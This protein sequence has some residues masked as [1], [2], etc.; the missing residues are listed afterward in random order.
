MDRFLIE[1]LRSGRAWVLV[2]SGPSSEMGYP[3]W[4]KLGKVALET[5]KA[6]HPGRL[7]RSIEAALHSGDFPGVFEDAQGILGAP[8]LLQALRAEL[9]PSRSA[10][11]YKLICRWPV[12]VYLTTNYDDELQRQLSTLG[13]TYISYTNS[14]EHMAHLV[15]DLQGAI[16]KLHA[17]LRS[18]SGLILTRSHYKAIQSDESWQYWRTKMTSVFQMTSLVV[19]GHSLSD[20]NFQHVL[21]AA[22]QGAGVQLPVCWIAPDIT[23]DQAQ[24]YLEKFRIRVISYNNRDGDHANLFRLLEQITDFIPARTSVRISDYGKRVIEHHGSAAPAFFVFNHLAART[25]YQEKRREILIAAI[26]SAAPTLAELPSFTIK[27]ALERAGWPSGI[28]LPNDVELDVGTVA[29]DRGLL[30]KEA[31]AYKLATRGLEVSGDNRRAFQHIHDRFN[32]A[33]ARR[34]RAD[35][36]SVS[37]E[38][39][40]NL[41]RDIEAAL[42]GY[43]REGG[44]TLASLLFSAGS[45]SERVVVP[46]SVLRFMNE[47]SAQYGDLLDRQVFMRT[48]L[49]IF[50][51]AGSAERDYLG[52]LAQ[53]FFGF[54]ALGAFG[55]VAVERLQHSKGTVWLLDSN[56]QIA[57]LAIG[58]VTSDVWQ[59][60]VR[61]F[62]MSQIRFFTLDR[63]FEEI[64]EHWWFAEKMVKQHGPASRTVIAAAL[65]ESPFHRSNLFLE[66]FVRW[67]AAGN[68]ADWESYMFQVFGTRSPTVEHIRKRLLEY[69]IEVLS[70]A[71][72]PGFKE[73]DFAVRDEHANEIARLRSRQGRA[74]AGS[75]EEQLRAPYKKAL[76]EAEALVVVQRERSGNYHMLS[77]EG[78]TSPAW[79]VSDTSILNAINMNIGGLRVTWQPEAF[80][81]FAA[82]LSTAEGGRAAERAFD[83]LLWGLAQTG[84]SL[85][86]QKAAEKVL[87]GVIDQATVTIQEM[88]QMYEATLAEK[89]GEPLESVLAKLDPI[90]RPL[91]ALQLANEVSQ[92]ESS[93]RILA[94]TRA[95]EAKRRAVSAEKALKEVERYRSKMEAKKERGRKKARKQKSKIRKH[96]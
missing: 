22:K 11:I 51:D 74:P 80:L 43:F 52:R 66:G 3:S 31:D 32:A 60:C 6:D 49:R 30:A 65:G 17:D 57:I 75:D 40:D 29:I 16:F 7:I 13:E 56:V 87:G 10:E 91:A 21:Q 96:K 9:K 27:M 95:E 24:E 45:A 77:N 37:A 8:R 63:L 94:E 20:P 83:T 84:L 33:V 50:T 19:V 23:L 81:R 14:E 1:Y 90:D 25:D 64:R 18:E 26:E 55:D 4:N 5:V 79:F 67:Q 48:S 92:T 78:V 28:P 93:R 36:P 69:G 34:I 12:P 35:F 89:Y 73:Q 76:P 42:T 59:E 15:P 44:L 86:D 53:G 58:S 88:R 2:G 39:A 71:D 54:H 61:R 70:F 41:A 62:A 85:L 47:A 46:P 82:T 72:W 68:P 38:R